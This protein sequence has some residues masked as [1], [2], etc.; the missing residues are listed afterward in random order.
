MIPLAPARF[1]TTTGWPISTESRA[2]TARDMT[3]V[4]PPGGKGTIIL[5]GLAGYGCA[6][7][8]EMKTRTQKEK[9][10]KRLIRG[11][12]ALEAP[13]LRYPRAAAAQVPPRRRTPRRGGAAARRSAPD[14][15]R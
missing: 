14:R 13:G 15:R 1:S 2:A 7:A 3:S 9:K 4:T 11:I 6:S 8:F 5:S 10:A 12:A